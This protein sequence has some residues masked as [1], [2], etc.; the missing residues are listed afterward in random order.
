[1]SR[2]GKSVVFLNIFFMKIVFEPFKQL[3]LSFWEKLYGTFQRGRGRVLNY[4]YIEK[5]SSYRL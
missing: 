2:R 4:V 3:K 5:E 1:V